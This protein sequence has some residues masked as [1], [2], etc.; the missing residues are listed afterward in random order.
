MGGRSVG[1]LEETKPK[2]HTYFNC[3]TRYRFPL[4]GEGGSPG[5]GKEACQWDFGPSSAQL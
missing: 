5:L 2:L 4:V 1:S 3:F